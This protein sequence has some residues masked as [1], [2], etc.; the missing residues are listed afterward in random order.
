MEIIMKIMDSHTHLGFAKNEKTIKEYIGNIE[1]AGACVFSPPPLEYD[2]QIGKDFYTRLKEVINF[3]AEYKDI[4]FPIVWIHPYEEDIFKKIDICAEKDIAGFKIICSNF[5]VGEEQVIE[6]LKH[7]SNIGKPVFFHSG[8]LWDGQNSSI[9]NRPA[10]WEALINIKGLK[11]SLGHCS[12]PWT[13]ECI[14]VYGKFLNAASKGDKAEMF[15]DITPGTPEIYR[16]DLLTKLFSV[17]YD[18]GNNIFFGTDCNAEAYNSSRLSNWLKI[19]KELL[20]ELGVSKEVRKNLY[21]NNILRFLGKSTAKVKKHIP[22]P[23]NANHWSPLCADVPSIIE[24][25]YKKI[26]F[27]KAF[28]GEFHEALESIKISDA[29]SIEDYNLKET[30]GKR[31]LLSFLF[32]CKNTEEE[33]VKKGISREILY[34]TLSDLAIWTEI[35]SR[36]KGELYL[37]E[38][39]WLS[40][41]LKARLF[42]LGRLQFCLGKSEFDI[43][44]HNISKGDNVIEVHIPSNGEPLTYDACVKSFSKARAFFADY[45]P[46]FDY[47]CFTCHSWLLDSSLKEIL[48]SDSNI[49]KFQTMFKL[50]KEEKS[51]AILNYVFEWGTRPEDIKN[52]SCTSSFAEN[53]KK[54]VLSGK[55][56]Y[57]GFGIAQ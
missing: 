49:L 4:L 7:I 45:F 23:D 22:V 38:L 42:K 3:T 46:D 27:N 50:I 34:D 29:I 33:Y 43:P 37:G 13:D 21:Y 57:V 26:G 53:V 39:I 25:Y 51:N 18:V 2:P 28:D 55:S 56:F 31:N 48:K 6:V 9:Y 47:K 16:R 40:L 54:R 14:A 17:G 32:L 5:H 15:L 35:W 12:W 52:A 41:H 44:H 8:I 30:D 36:K 11:F 19:D 1:I 10:N 24:N 20:D